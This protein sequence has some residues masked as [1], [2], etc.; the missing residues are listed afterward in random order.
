LF[1]DSNGDNKI[2]VWSYYKD[3]VEIY[4]EVDS[5]LSAG[6]PDQYR[7]IHS[8]GSKWGVD[9]D[10]DGHIKSWKIISPEEVSQEILQA[11]IKKDVARLQALLIT[12]QEI[13]ALELPADTAGRIR[14]SLKA[15]PAKFSDTVSKLNG[16]IGPK[17]TWIHVELATPQCIPADI[18]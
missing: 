1:Y 9:P 17:A 5:S 4:R 10:R 14:E 12:E 11:V 6:K 2:D 16:K 3:G 18:A 8:G 7:W 13:K 15:A